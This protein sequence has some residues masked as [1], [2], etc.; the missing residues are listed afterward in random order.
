MG[1]IS[2]L[3]FDLCNMCDHQ[4]TGEFR[5]KAPCSCL[6]QASSGT[7]SRPW[8]RLY[9][10][11]PVNIL[12]QMDS[13]VDHH[14]S[15]QPV[16]NTNILSSKYNHQKHHRDLYSSENRSCTYK[17]LSTPMG[18]DYVVIGFDMEVQPLVTHN[19]A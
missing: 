17:S 8:H 5:H 9:I 2:T 6:E 4:G 13:S 11:L 10:R 14:H 1:N 19:A 3:L 15:I 18:V 12:D 16:T 7:I